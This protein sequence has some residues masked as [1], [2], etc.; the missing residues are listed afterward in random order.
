MKFREP[1]RCTYRPRRARS[2]EWRVVALCVSGDSR[3]A[4]GRDR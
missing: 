3:R 1:P 2:R 4:P